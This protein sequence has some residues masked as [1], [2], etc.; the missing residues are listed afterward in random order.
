MSDGVWSAGLWF[1]QNGRILSL[2]K[3][4]CNCFGRAVYRTQELNVQGL[5]N[6]YL[7]CVFYLNL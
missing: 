1:K 4:I 5:L 3:K 7:E 2:K 6:S